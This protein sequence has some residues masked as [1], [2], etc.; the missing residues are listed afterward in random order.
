MSGTCKLCGFW[1]KPRG[2]A[3]TDGPLRSCACQKMHY[4]YNIRNAEVKSDECRIED[5]ECWG[6]LT[7]P[8]FGCIHFT[9][10]NT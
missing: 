4:G 10:D 8:D 1:G 9:K 5:D 7:G 2:M 6:M 3:N